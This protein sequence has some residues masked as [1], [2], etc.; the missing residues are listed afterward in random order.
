VSARPLAAALALLVASLAAD[1]A[2][3]P[4]AFKLRTDPRVEHAIDLKEVFQG[5]Q[6]FGRDPR[7]VIMTIRKPRIVAADAAAKWLRPD[8]E[9]LGLVVNGKARAYPLRI[10]QVHELVNDV[11]GGRPVAP[12]Y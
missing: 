6:S 4:S 5:V 8:A 12:N 9:V 2:K 10:L 3:S 1:E 7:D 11:L